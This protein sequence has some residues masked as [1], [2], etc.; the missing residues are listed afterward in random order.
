MRKRLIALFV[1]TLTIFGMT[2]VVLA[3]NNPFDDVPT[4]HWAYAAVNKL[5]EEGIV[6]GDGH[7]KFG[8]DKLLTRYEMAQLVGKAISHADKADA[9]NK[10]LIDK[11]AKEYSEELKNLGV[12]VQALETKDDK[13]MKFSGLGWA[14]YEWNN[15][16]HD[17]SSY[18]SFTGIPT[19]S[20]DIW[21][22][23]LLYADKKIDDNSR[24]RITIGGDSVDNVSSSSSSSPFQF[25]EGYYESKAG[26]VTWAAGRFFEFNGDRFL[27]G[28]PWADGVRVSFGKDVITTIREV[29]QGVY[30]WNMADVHTNLNKNTELWLEYV[31]D[32]NR[33]MYDSKAIGLVYKGIPN[34]TLNGDFGI[35]SAT[36]AKSEAGGSTPC[37]Y[38]VQAKYKGAIPSLVGSNGFSVNYRH[39]DYGFDPYGYASGLDLPQPYNW[40]YPGFGGALDNRSGFSFGAEQ[41]ISPN[42][43]LLLNYG[44]LKA[45][46]LS[47][48]TQKDQKYFIAQM[49][50][51]F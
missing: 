43:I 14:R 45:N 3:A 44:L 6:D 28:G 50:Y 47:V 36:T 31:G 8:G 7:G 38:Y 33:V 13:N 40:S 10:A 48:V 17:N 12:R 49:M 27:W 22:R 41:T 39:G 25:Y 16:P 37:G 2:N 42:A 9:E 26:N 15:A 20:N 19:G 32:H 51:F 23:L 35:N 1:V 18:S 24:V 30:N 5:V 4:K 29:K 34:I 21:T 11:L 46:T